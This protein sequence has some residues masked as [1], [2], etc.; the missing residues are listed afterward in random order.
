MTLVSLAPGYFGKLPL[1]TD[2]VRRHSKAPVAI[3]F[4]RWLE[5]GVAWAAERH[6]P[7]LDPLLDGLPVVR[8]VYRGRLAGELLGGV[9]VASTDRASRRFPFAVF[10]QRPEGDPAGA[11]HLIPRV[12]SPALDHA[13]AVVRKLPPDLASL[14]YRLA[15][16]THAVVTPTAETATTPGQLLAGETLAGMQGRELPRC[17]AGQVRQVIRSLLAVRRHLGGRGLPSAGLRFPL[18]PYVA[19][20]DVGVSNWLALAQVVL[21][22]LGRASFFWISPQAGLPGY[23]DVHFRTPTA[24]SLLHLLDRQLKTSRLF[25]LCE[26]DPGS[27]IPGAGRAGEEDPPP[28][29][30]LLQVL[31]QVR[32]PPGYGRA[33]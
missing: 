28:D 15:A 32:W 33:I 31:D 14:Q 9:L 20:P 22:D 24:T 4:E 5:E 27:G 10:L 17:S 2:F 7:R 29:T 6:G 25:D 3:E 26:E 1:A 8:F 11:T 21:G 18:S 30:P 12:L 19:D 13:L 23:L 16:M